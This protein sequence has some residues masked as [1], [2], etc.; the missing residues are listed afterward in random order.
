MDKSQ[1]IREDRAL[2]ALFEAARARPPLPASAFLSLLEADAVAALPQR[3]VETGARR[4]G[5]Q[6]GFGF[7][8]LFAASGLSL[9]AAAGVIIGFASP[10]LVSP[11][12]TLTD[13]G[14]E[15]AT[16]YTFLPGADLAAL[17]E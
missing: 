9:S 3:P 5:L 8:G 10:D 16:L 13:S 6:W 4:R 7:P 2:D 12:A 15:I 1:D 11:Y 14:D 17:D